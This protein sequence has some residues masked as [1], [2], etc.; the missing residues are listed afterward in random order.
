MV[1]EV[2]ANKNMQVFSKQT[3]A[4]RQKMAH[5]QA[6]TQAISQAVT[7]LLLAPCNKML[8]PCSLVITGEAC[9]L[10]V[11]KSMYLLVIDYS[12]LWEYFCI[13]CSA[14]LIQYLLRM[15]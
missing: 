3:P 8:V 10:V 5:A 13:S 4:K 12:E 2:K 15:R 1:S 14:I 6:M 11:G 9:C 7:I